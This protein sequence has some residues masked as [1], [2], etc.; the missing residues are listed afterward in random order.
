MI[1]KI[2]RFFS[3]R[4]IPL[5]QR[6]FVFFLTASIISSPPETTLISLPAAAFHARHSR[7]PTVLKNEEL[8]I[9]KSCIFLRAVTWKG[10]ILISNV[11][12]T[13][14]DSFCFR[15]F[16]KLMNSTVDPSS[17]WYDPP[18]MWFWFRDSFVWWK[19]IDANFALHLCWAIL[20]LCHWSNLLFVH[21][22]Y[23]Y[24]HPERV[25]FGSVVLV[26]NFVELIAPGSLNTA[27]RRAEEPLTSS[28]SQPQNFSSN[29]IEYSCS[30]Y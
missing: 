20:V 22:L 1:S 23:S 25:S 7:G 30:P 17:S 15:N 19:Y 6:L 13:D 16:D 14:Y 5:F 11:E 26:Q 9:V 27:T 28:K 3:T 12:G 4:S 29:I 10:D 18:S 8:K 21:P 2:W 24:G